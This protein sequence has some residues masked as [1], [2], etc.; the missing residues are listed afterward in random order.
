MPY[1]T[2][3]DS[4]GGG[5]CGER[6]GQFRGGPFADEALVPVRLACGS[7]ESPPGFARI[8]STEATAR[9]ATAHVHGA[10]N[11]AASTS[12][13]PTPDNRGQNPRPPPGLWGHQLIAELMNALA[14]V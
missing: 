12:R 7:D 9:S 2:L 1:T 14:D 4:P 11:E 13:Y 3:L 8:Y 6:A 5:G 10:L